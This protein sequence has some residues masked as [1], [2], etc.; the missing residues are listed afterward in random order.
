V[1]TT[2]LTANRLGRKGIG[3]ELNPVWA[4]ES[5]DRVVRDAPLFNGMAL[6]EAS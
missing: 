6:E 4:Q 5:R 1:G 2:V 3:I